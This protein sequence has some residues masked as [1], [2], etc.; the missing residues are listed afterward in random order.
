MQMS[1]IPLI[2]CILLFQPTF[3]TEV[4]KLIDE[5]NKSISTPVELRCGEYSF[6]LKMNPWQHPIFDE[7]MQRLLALFTSL[8]SGCGGVIYLMSD[9]METVRDEIFQVY[10]ER[11]HALIVRHIEKFT[12][13]MNMVQVSLLG[14]HRTWAALLLTKSRDELKYLPLETRTIW[15]PI[16]LDLDKFG[17]IYTK[18][19]SESQSESYLEIKRSALSPVPRAASSTLLQSYSQENNSPQPEP[20]ISAASATVPVTPSGHSDDTLTPKVDFSSCQKLDWTENT[21]DWQKYVKVKKVKIDDIVGSCPIWNPTEPMKVTPDRDSLRYLFESE[22]NMD[23]TL[24][25]TTTKEPGFAIVCRTWQ[26]HT[27]DDDA[28]EDLPQGHICDILTVT[29]T[30]SLTFWVV[31]DICDESCFESQMKYLMTTGRMLKYQITQQSTGDLSN[32]WIDCRLLPLTT[33][34][35]MKTTVKLRSQE[36]QEIQRHLYEMCHE[37]VEFDCLQQAV[38]KVILSKECPLKRCVG[39][40]TSISLTVQQAEVLMHKAKV[41]YITGPAGSGKSYTAAL[42]YKMYGKDR[43]VYM[44]TTKEF[45]GYLKFSGCTGT[46]VLGDQDLLREIRSGTFHNK[47]CVVIDD[48]HRFKCTKKSIKK[49]FKTLKKNTEMSLCLQTIITSPSTG[50]DSK[51]YTTA[52]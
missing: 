36:C 48:C 39:E 52:S 3:T 32:L 12:L 35:N 33:P 50:K 17:H 37:G 16:T 22:K 14:T 41:N 19:E 29:D 23:E 2:F 49:L 10:K 43:S 20:E 46:L 51:V 25:K 13:Q 40:Y 34:I 47:I 1:I 4:D 6:Q 30:G 7:N 9:D 18:P 15:K 5:L 8:R 31:V 28:I 24:R 45:L 38:A 26:F 11:L 27:S 44:C 21:K 42:L